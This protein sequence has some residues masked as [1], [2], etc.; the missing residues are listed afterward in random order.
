M[1]LSFSLSHPVVIGTNHPHSKEHERM[2]KGRGCGFGRKKLRTS[3]RALNPKQSTTQ[4][5]LRLT[6]QDK[7][8]KCHARK[9]DSNHPPRIP[10][11]TDPLGH[12]SQS[13]TNRTKPVDDLADDPIGENRAHLNA[14]NRTTKPIG[15]LDRNSIQPCQAVPQDRDFCKLDAI[16][17]RQT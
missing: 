2:Q 13:G 3:H 11:N 7:Q 10:K 1:A 12:R 17:S 6:H 14:A 4:S 5:D 16:I 8:C 9:L 15:H